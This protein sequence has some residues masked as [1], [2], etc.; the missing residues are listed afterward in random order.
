MIRLDPKS[1]ALVM[2]DLQKGIV[3]RQ[4]APRSSAE[5]VAGAMAQ[6][7]RFRA[8]GAK[9]VW[10][11]VGWEADFADAVK[12][13]VDEPMPR[14]PGGLPADFAELVAGLDA[15]GDFHVRKRQWGAFYG[16]DLDLQLRR[17]GIDTIALGG[18]ATN[19]GVESTA[20]A[21]WEH[22][23]AVV[24]LEDL[25]ASMAAEHHAF[26]VSHIFPR[27]ARVRT[28]AEIELES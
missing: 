8:A 21:A 19:F 26:A 9:I 10:V 4:V 13:P 20:R 2:I 14:P 23:Y 18:I 11:T 28:S 12:T 15:P 1:T 25:C 5:V 7:R 16:T 22:G 6:A 24:V 3:A 17:R 27:I